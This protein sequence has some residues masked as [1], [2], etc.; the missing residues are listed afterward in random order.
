MGLDEWFN[1]KIIAAFAL[2][3]HTSVIGVLRKDEKA[4]PFPLLKQ[5]NGLLTQEIYCIPRRR[6]AS[7]RQENL[8]GETQ[9]SFTVN[10]GCVQ[11]MLFCC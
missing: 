2:K 11:N 8:Q 9:E 5:Y 10:N 3:L 4:V 6:K 7:Y 1:D